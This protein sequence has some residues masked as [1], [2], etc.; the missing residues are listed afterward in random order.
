M[1]FRTVATDVRRRIPL[2]CN[3]V[4]LLTSS[5]TSIGFMESFDL[6]HWTRIGAMNRPRM[7]W[8][9]INSLRVRFMGS[10]PLDPVSATEP[11]NYTIKIWSLRRTANYGSPHVNERPLKVLG[12]T[13][14]SD[15]RTVFIEIPEVQPTWGMEIK[16]ALRGADGTPFTRILHN[17]IHRLQSGPANNDN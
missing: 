15:E 11:N 7:V 16:A 1:N 8:L 9:I 6:Q 13:L 10:D 2:T 4:R 17:T 3:A 12:A 5:A 14:A